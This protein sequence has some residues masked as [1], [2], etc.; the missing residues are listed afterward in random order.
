MRSI[1]VVLGLGF[2]V[3]MMMMAVSVGSASATWDLCTNVGAG[4]GSFKDPACQEK[5][6][7]GAW[8]WKEVATSNLV[9]LLNVAGGKLKLEDMKAETQIEC[10]GEGEGTVGSGNKDVINSITATGCTFIKRGACSE[11]PA[12]TAAAVHLPW[13]TELQLVGTATWDSIKSSGAGTPGWEVKCTVGGILKV[14]DT[15]EGEAKTKMKNLANG[16][17]EAAFEGEAS[18]KAKCSIGG[19]E[20]GLLNGAGVV[21]A[22]GGHGLQFLAP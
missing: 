12:P 9:K 4:N 6:A 1:K 5:E 15:C 17:V 19:A 16:T 11:T 8:E 20:Q 10:T 14:V 7:K 22:V 3:V 18:G 21:E 2:A 13:S